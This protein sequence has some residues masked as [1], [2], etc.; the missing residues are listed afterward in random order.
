M[1]QGKDRLIGELLFHTK[2]GNK[3]PVRV[4]RGDGIFTVERTMEDGRLERR[5]KSDPYKGDLGD[6]ISEATLVWHDLE[7]EGVEQISK[8]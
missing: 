5:S 2:T 6:Y 4:Y 1:R 8:F 7:R 3:A